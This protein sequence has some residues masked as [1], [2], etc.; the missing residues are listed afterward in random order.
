LLAKK[1]LKQLVNVP[2]IAI[3]KEVIVKSF[4][5]RSPSLINNTINIV[6]D[7][8]QGSHAKN[9]HL[10]Q[11]DSYS[12]LELTLVYLFNFDRSIYTTM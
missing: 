6:I 5:S 1:E 12:E 2:Y 8:I 9:C 4:L 7:V 10:L 3:K 11:V